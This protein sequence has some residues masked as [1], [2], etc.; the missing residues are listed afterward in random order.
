MEV[1]ILLTRPLQK[2]ILLCVCFFGGD[3]EV[4]S[5][6]VLNTILCF[7]PVWKRE[8]FFTFLM[9]LDLHN[10]NLVSFDRY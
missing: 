10:N 8:K 4:V 2:C 5:K 6:T 7:Y 3:W 1:K 9:Y